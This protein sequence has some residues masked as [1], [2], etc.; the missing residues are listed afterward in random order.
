MNNISPKC[1]NS[2]SQQKWNQW[3]RKC[4][5]DFTGLIWKYLVQFPSS[6]GSIPFPLH[7]G[8]RLGRCHWQEGSIPILFLLLPDPSS[9]P[10]WRLGPSWW[11][12]KLRVCLGTKGGN[13]VVIYDRNTCPW[14]AYCKLQLIKLCLYE[15]SVQLI[16]LRDA[17][18]MITVYFIFSL[19]PG[20]S[21]VERPY[22]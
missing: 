22:Q 3:V 11:H 21:S 16:S 10:I 8:K 19:L 5:R 13:K 4:L 12:T 1:K 9:T 2:S 14:P 20:M 15:L 7:I 6:L 18:L 17:S